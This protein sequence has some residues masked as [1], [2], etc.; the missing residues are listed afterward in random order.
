MHNFRSKI[1][2]VPHQ[3]LPCTAYIQTFQNFLLNPLED[4]EGLLILCKHNEVHISCTIKLSTEERKPHPPSLLPSLELQ[5]H[6]YESRRPNK[7]SWSFTLVLNF[8]S[9][10]SQWEF[11]L[12]TLVITPDSL[13]CFVN[14]FYFHTSI[15]FSMIFVTCFVGLLISEINLN[16]DFEPITIWFQTFLKT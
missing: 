9:Y 14:I 4:E 8:E 5:S 2:F 12:N 11:V 16:W 13:Q 15:F 3:N 6:T 1:D 7:I 10:S